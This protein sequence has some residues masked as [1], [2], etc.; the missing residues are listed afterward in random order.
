MAIVVAT[1]GLAIAGAAPAADVGANDDTG[2]WAPNAGSAFFSQMAGLKLKQSVMTTRWVPSDPMTIQDQDAL[3][4]AIPE[5]ERAGLRVVLA[6]YPYPPREVEAGLAH[7]AA[8]AAWLGAV[9]A[10]Y[11]S[12]KQYAVMNEPN[13]PAFL[14]PQFRT[15]GTNASAP[16]AGAFLAAG[17]DALKA[18][19]PTI[20]VIGLGLSPRGNDRPAAPNNVS[21]SPVRFL[22]ALGA[23]YRASGREKPLMDGL[24][25]HPYPDRATDDLDQSY[26]WPNAGFVDLGRIKQALWD[27]FRDTPQP[28]TVNGLRLYLDEVG[29]QVDTEGLLGYSGDENVAVTDEASQAGIYSSLVHQVACDPHVA[30][31]NFFGFYDGVERDGFQAA[32]HRV[33]GT[34]RASAASVQEAITETEPGCQGVPSAWYPA[35]RVIGAE[36]L[37]WRIEAR[38]LIRVTAQAAEGANVMACLLPGHLGGAAAALAMES[39]TATSAGCVAAKVLPRRPVTFTFRREGQLRPVTAAIRFVAESST[40][41]SRTFSRTVR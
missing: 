3:D 26:S 24:S 15:N 13:Q 11:P 29:W 19:D 14:R 12:V 27:A 41:R 38:R 36:A 5:A 22:A 6:V 4:R 2:K 20:R 21:T 32:L 1:A 17:Y 8:F 31:L 28:T 30:E 10:R 37:S 34:P 25:F 39:R 7:P 33:D 9:A 18:V 40:R 16:I 35:K 23:W